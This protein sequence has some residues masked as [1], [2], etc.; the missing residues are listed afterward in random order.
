MKAEEDLNGGRKEEVDYNTWSQERELALKE[1]KQKTKGL[2]RNE[3]AEYLEI[4]KIEIELPEIPRF[5]SLIEVNK[6]ADCPMHHE[7]YSRRT[8]IDC[9]NCSFF[10]KIKTVPKTKCEFVICSFQGEE[11]FYS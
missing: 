10:Y 9:Y 8:L 5:C 4:E 1:R 2:N 6:Y 11:G 3:I 7:F